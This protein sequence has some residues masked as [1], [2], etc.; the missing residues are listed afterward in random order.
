MVQLSCF[1]LP[2]SGAP[3]E[4]RE[5]EREREKVETEPSLTMTPRN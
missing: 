1:L 5:M 2:A 3:G 4:M